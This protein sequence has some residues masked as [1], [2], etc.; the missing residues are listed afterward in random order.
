MSVARGLQLIHDLIILGCS[1]LSATNT[2]WAF[3]V[4]KVV[5]SDDSLK[6]MGDHNNR[7]IT[8]LLFLNIQDGVLDFGFTLRVK[9]GGSLVKHENL[10]LL[11]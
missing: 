8:F 4:E 2:C 3:Q 5:C 9:S 1:L 10:R 7:K 11:D 6:A